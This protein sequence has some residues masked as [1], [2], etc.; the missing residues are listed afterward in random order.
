MIHMYHMMINREIAMTRR[1]L[2]RLLTG[3]LTAT[4]VTQSATAR[5]PGARKGE[6]R[7]RQDFPALRKS[8]AGHGHV[9][10]DSAAMAQR[11]IAVTDALLGFYERGNA[12]PGK[13]QH[14]MARQAYELYEAARQT[15]ARFI[16]ASRA[17][18]EVAGIAAEELMRDLD[19]RGVAIRAGDLSAL[20]LLKHWGVSEAARASCYLYTTQAD[21]DALIEALH[22]SV[23]K[24]LGT[25]S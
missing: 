8:P 1:E 14:A 22:Q 25:T 4:A 24:R 12:N 3:A 16:N 23:A 18:E 13:T 7:W 6:E 11:P 5:S 10:L 15:L 9:Y 17:E 19:A 20:P 21:I 2:G